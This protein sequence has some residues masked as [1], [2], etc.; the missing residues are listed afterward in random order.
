MWADLL[1]LLPTL[2]GWT[3]GHAEPF[4]LPGSWSPGGVQED[5]PAKPPASGADTLLA[6]GMLLTWNQ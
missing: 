3:G 5:M 6:P 1:S 4:A 2:Q